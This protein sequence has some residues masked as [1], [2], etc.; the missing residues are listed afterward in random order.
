MK[1]FMILSVLCSVI[2]AVR[3][4]DLF[5]SEEREYSYGWLAAACGWIS[6]WSILAFKM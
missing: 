5:M 3:F 4:V 6:N 2:C 1:L